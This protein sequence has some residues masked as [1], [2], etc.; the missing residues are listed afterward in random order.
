MNLQ[1][2]DGEFYYIREV[3]RAHGNADVSHDPKTIATY[4]RLQSSAAFDAGEIEICAYLA[5][6]AIKINE[7]ARN[8]HEPRWDDA[9]AILDDLVALRMGN[10]T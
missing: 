8:S 5:T 2:K 7:D 3:V 4:M 1:W 9:L 6:A 10:R